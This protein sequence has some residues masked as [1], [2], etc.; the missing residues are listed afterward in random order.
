M[1]PNQ[2]YMVPLCHGGLK[3]DGNKEAFAL[4]GNLD[5]ISDE[6]EAPVRLLEDV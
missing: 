1:T 5:K 4:A 6:S 3:N 2:R